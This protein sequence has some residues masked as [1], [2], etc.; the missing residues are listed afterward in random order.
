MRHG[1]T[2]LHDFQTPIG[3]RTQ[4]LAMRHYETSAIRDTCKESE[5]ELLA[6]KYPPESLRVAEWT[7][8]Q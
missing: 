1:Y 2:I 5:L 3:T 4:T 7:L 8:P 6:Q